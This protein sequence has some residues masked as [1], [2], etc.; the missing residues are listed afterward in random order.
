MT[1][2]I[3]NLKKVVCASRHYVTIVQEDRFNIRVDQASFFDIF[4][5]VFNVTNLESFI[6]EH[7]T[8]R[9]CVDAAT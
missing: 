9:T 2:L 1:K 5:H 3:Q 4:K 7:I 6:A 8:E